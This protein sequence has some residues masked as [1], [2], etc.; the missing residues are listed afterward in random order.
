MLAKWLFPSA[1]EIIV[2]I[3]LSFAAATLLGGT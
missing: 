2:I 3:S 1:V